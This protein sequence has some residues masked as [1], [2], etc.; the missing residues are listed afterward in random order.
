M[1]NRYGRGI[2]AV[3]A[4]ILPP[5]TS[6]IIIKIQSKEPALN[7]QAKLVN[8]DEVAI[9]IDMLKNLGESIFDGEII[10]PQQNIEE[11]SPPSLRKVG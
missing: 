11:S 3:E 5:I 1:S 4:L 9:L 7:V 10:F 2:P 6:D 8:L